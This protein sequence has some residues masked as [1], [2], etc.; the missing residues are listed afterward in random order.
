MPVTLGEGSGVIYEADVPVAMRDGVV[1]RCNVFRPADGRPAPALIQRQPYNKDAAQTYVY[2]HPAWYARQGYATVIEDSRGRYASEGTFYPLRRDAEDGFDTIEWLA[3]QPWCNGKVASFGFSIPGINQLLAAAEQPP[4]LVAAAPGFYPA[5]MY[6]GF[7]HVG[8]TFGL[9]AVMDWGMLLAPEEARRQGRADLLPAIRA[10]AAAVGRWHP[11]IPLREIPFLLEPPLMPFLADYVNHP[12][13]G[14][15]WR[16]FAL[17]HRIPAI[18]VPCLH[19]SG[20]YDSFITQTIESYERFA[21]L[22]RAEHRLLIGPWYHI[23][24]TQQVGCIDFGQDARNIVDEAQLAWFEAQL[25]G[26]R[27]AL[28]RMAP[29]RLFVTGANRW[30]EPPRWPI[31]GARFE[32]LYLHSDGRA[33]SLSGSGRLSFEA[34]GEEPPDFFVYGPDNPV[35]SAGGHSCCLPQNTPMG[36]ADQRAVELRNDVLVYSSAPLEAPLFVAGKV[37]A[38]LHAATTAADTDFVV[39]LCDVAPDGRSINLQEGV[40][41]AR[42]REGS[43]IEKPVEPNRVEPYHIEVGVVCHEFGRGHRIRVQVASSN[44]PAWDRNPNTGGPPGSEPPFSLVVANQTVC[45][46]ARRPSRLELPMVRG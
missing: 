29:V 1:L 37:S 8:G 35:Q 20:W 33:N 45:H 12:S 30:I 6:E 19:V 15:Y 3:R 13:H 7:T 38:V 41:R 11:T 23:P 22:G 39:K 27:A 44:F 31:P 43:G 2:A 36:P 17:D 14:S 5:G 46:D 28:E 4:H 34:P 42:Y 18:G 16:E 25:K 9:A 26:N 10:A 24:W 32:N 40:V 21:E